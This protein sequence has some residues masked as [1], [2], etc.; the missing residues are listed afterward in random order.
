MFINVQS[1][2]TRRQMTHYFAFLQHSKNSDENLNVFVRNTLFSN[3]Q[4]TFFPDKG[5]FCIFTALKKLVAQP[6][7]N[8]VFLA[9]TK[10]A[11]YD[12]SGIF[13]YI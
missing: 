13:S 3:N 9:K 12:K 4:I 8:K 1:I 7:A 2:C 5:L 10:N 6:K 11:F